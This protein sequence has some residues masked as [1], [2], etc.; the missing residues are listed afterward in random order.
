MPNIIEVA[1][2][3]GGFSTL[4]K[5]AKIA[6]IVETL[7]NDGPFT[8]FAPTDEAFSK[9]PSETL[10]ELLNEPKKLKEILLY[11]IIKGKMMTSAAK[12][13]TGPMDVESL[14]GQKIKLDPLNHLINDVAKFIKPDVEANNGVIH[15]IDTVLM[16]S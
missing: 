13:F 16:P 7:S 4:L 14:Q 5:A 1:S 3:E 9:I 10:N 12:D 8:F 6:G 15:V 11:H 2:K